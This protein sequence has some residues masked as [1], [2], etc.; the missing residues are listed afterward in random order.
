MRYG[1]VLGIAIGIILLS[2]LVFAAEPFKEKKYVAT[3]D[4]DGVQRVEMMS[5]S[6][7]F[8]PNLIVVKVNVPVELKV[9]GEGGL[10][11]HDISLKA[12]EAGIDFVLELGS[13]PQPVRF[14]P[15]RTGRYEFVCTKKLLFFESHKERGMHGALL[16]VE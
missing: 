13:E 16:V 4:S 2:R 8:D 14:T 3:T 5:G 1:K 12:P 15:T 11:P 7:Y 6:Y 9:K 10:T